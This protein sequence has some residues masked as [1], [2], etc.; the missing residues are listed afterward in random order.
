MHPVQCAEK[1]R[2]GR[3]DGSTYRDRKTFSCVIR[4]RHSGALN[5]SNS[6]CG[7][8][9]PLMRF[10]IPVQFATR[11]RLFSVFSPFSVRR[12]ED[13]RLCSVKI[14]F[15][16]QKAFRIWSM[17]SVLKKNVLFSIRSHSTVVF[18]SV[19]RLGFGTIIRQGLHSVIRQRSSFSHS[20]IVVD[21]VDVVDVGIGVYRGFVLVDFCILLQSLEL[22]G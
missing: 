2:K 13:I 3:D 22:Q 5:T 14:E 11:G 6:A 9:N 15:M 1:E 10:S 12:T 21:V 16:A 7:M 19:I 17:E 20:T 18:R 8:Q 4:K